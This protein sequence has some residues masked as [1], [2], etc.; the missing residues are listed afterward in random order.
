MA[1]MNGWVGSMSG[2]DW[3]WM[4]IGLLALS[5]VAGAA[6]VAATRYLRRSRTAPAIEPPPRRDAEKVLADRFARS[7]IDE[8]E[9]WQRL[10]A[11][12]AGDGS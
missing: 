2:W 4:V 7:E 5:A 11:L 10:L 6:V 9:Y 3:T 12:R 1:M 8:D